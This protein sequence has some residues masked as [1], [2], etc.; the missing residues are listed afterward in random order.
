MHKETHKLLRGYC[1]KQTNN[2]NIIWIMLFDSFRKDSVEGV[3]IAVKQ[4]NGTEYNYYLEL[5]ANVDG[6]L[7]RG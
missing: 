6:F 3:S 2:I 5:S 1:S 7:N 4:K